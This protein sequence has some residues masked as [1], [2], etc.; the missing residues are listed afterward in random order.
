MAIR[1]IILN[2]PDE[3]ILALSQKALQENRTLESYLERLAVI[4]SGLTYPDL[5]IEIVASDDISDTRAVVDPNWPEPRQQRTAALV[6][7]ILNL[8]R[9]KP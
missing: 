3:A 1:K 7:E 8:N 5:V 9:T 4:D 6:D 2:L